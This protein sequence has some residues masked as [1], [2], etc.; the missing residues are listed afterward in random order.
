MSGFGIGNVSNCVSREN[1]KACAKQ[2]NQEIS[3]RK[4]TYEEKIKIEEIQDLIEEM[5]K[6]SKEE[7]ELYE[8]QI[9][10]FKVAKDVIY[11]DKIIVKR[12]TLAPA[13]VS[14][15]VLPGMNGI[16]ASIILK[17]FSIEYLKKVVPHC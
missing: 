2:K 16:P 17:D 14:I 4:K 15:I 7:K 3:G 6:K 10:N 12:G 11:N 1:S 8:N 13:K 9:I 5:L